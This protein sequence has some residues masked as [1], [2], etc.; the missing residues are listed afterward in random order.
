VKVRQARYAVIGSPVAHS[1]SPVMQQAA[2]AALHIDAT[3]EAIE[4]TTDRV[5]DVF[6]QLRAEQYSGW[7]VTTPLKEAVMSLVDRATP[8][9]AAAR[10][11]NTIRA[12]RGGTL[13]AHNTDGAGFVRAIREL[14]SWEPSGTPVLI[15]GTGPAARAIAIALRASGEV[16]LA[17]WSRDAARAA[18]IASPP[19]GIVHLVVSALPADATLPPDIEQATND[20][21]MIFDLNYGRQRS[22]VAAMRGRRRS[23]GRPLL[24]HQGALSFE[25]WTGLTA[26]LAPMRSAIEKNSPPSQMSR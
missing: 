7:N 3:Y 10:A 21:T 5:R 8:E 12:E 26:P 14:W 20:D 4:T 11:A 19:A 13:T 18:Q 23:D 15:L 22:P 9:A 17:C 24:L 6:A 16:S 25:W 2:F 1:L